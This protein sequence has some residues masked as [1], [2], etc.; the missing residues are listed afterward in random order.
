[1]PFCDDCIVLYTE[2]EF[3]RVIVSLGMLVMYE[4]MSHFM[5]MS[6]SVFFFCV[7]ASIFCV[8]VKG[9]FRHLPVL[10]CGFKSKIK[11]STP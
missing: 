11:S 3:F 5:H 7:C 1:M 4:R 2:L 10:F 6:L 9:F 8:Y